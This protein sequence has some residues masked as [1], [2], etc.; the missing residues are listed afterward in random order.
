MR[1]NARKGATG[2][3]FTLFELILAIALSVTID[4]SLP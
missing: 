1:P 3:G 4:A 2:T